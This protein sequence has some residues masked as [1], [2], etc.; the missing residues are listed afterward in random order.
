MV[1]TA[2]S[3]YI[4]E[5][6]DG[7]LYTGCTPRLSDRV[8]AHNAGK[9]AK[10]TRSRLP[11]KLVYQESQ[12]SHSAALQREAVIKKMPRAQKIKLVIHN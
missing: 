4:L 3:V 6:G 8:A 10:Y 5:C 7:S 1:A 12:P 2:W 11:V 9:G